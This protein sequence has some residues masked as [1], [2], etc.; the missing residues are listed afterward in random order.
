MA[1]ALERRPNAPTARR[2]QTLIRLGARAERKSPDW[3]KGA[4]TPHGRL[5]QPYTEPFL[6]GHW[7]GSISRK[8]KAFPPREVGQSRLRAS[9]PSSLRN[10][11]R[12]HRKPAPKG[13]RNR[14]CEFQRPASTR[15]SSWWNLS[16][17][18]QRQP[19]KGF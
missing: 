9:K 12:P 14:G 17:S 15:F 19:P 1:S 2:F 8:A 18:H 5:G 10:P 6:P 4:H 13:E 3:P 7:P 16:A 11:S